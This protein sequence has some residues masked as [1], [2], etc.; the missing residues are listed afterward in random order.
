[1]SKLFVRATKQKL[2]FETIKGVLSVEDLW[3]LSLT[4]LNNV[5][6]ALYMKVQE[7]HEITFIKTKTAEDTTAA[8]RFDLVKFMIETKLAEKE[9]AEARAVAKAKRAKI[10][11]MIEEKQDEDL[12]D[13]TIKDLK[14][15]LKSLDVD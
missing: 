13:N 5:A 1:M 8:L 11:D 4:D 14:K 10:L 12:K 9:A 7:S 6:K 3:D 2:R 15:M